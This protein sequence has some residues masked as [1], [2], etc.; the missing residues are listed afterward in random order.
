MESYN[1]V[2][3]GHAGINN[4]TDGLRLGDNVVWQV[5]ELD[6]FRTMAELYVEQARR[7]KRHIVYMRYA[8]HEPILSDLTGVTVHEFDATSGFESFATAV[9]RAIADEGLLAF[10]VFD[11][12]TYLKH[13]WQSD[14]MVMNFFKVTCP[15]LYEL[16]TIAYFAFL[17][18][19]HTVTTIAGI[20]ETTQLLL[21]MHL[22]DDDVY[23]HPLKVWG[24]HSPTMF[25]PHRVT[26]EGEAIPVT[27][28]E[29]TARLFA[30]MSRKS[31]TADQWQVL[32]QSG[33]D[34]LAAQDEAMAAAVKDKLLAVLIGRDGRMVDLSSEHL[35]LDDLLLIARRE[36][37]T[38][39][40]GGKSVGMLVA[41]AILEHDPD[42]RFSARLEPHDSY[43]IGSDLFFTYII[44]NGWWKQWVA[45]KSPEGYFTV[46]A[47]LHELLATGRFP[48]AIREEFLHMLEYF[49]QSPIIVRSSSLLEDNFGNAFAGKYESVFCVNQGTPDERHRQFEDAIRTVYASAMSS[50]AL[51]YRQN[52]GLV[53][54][55]EQMAVLVQR[56][57]G[58][59]HGAAFFPHAAGVGN[60]SNLYVWDPS[61]DMDA[62][63][64][65]LVVG[66]GTRAVDRTHHDYARIVTLDEPTR[67]RLSDPEDLSRYSQRYVDVLNLRSNGLDALPLE[68]LVD[69]DI[70]ADW[71]NFVSPDPYALRVLRERKRPVK[72]VPRVVDFTGLLSATEFPAYMRDVLATVSGAY[73]YPVDIEFTL[74]FD[75][76]GYWKVSLVQCRPLQTRGLGKAVPVPELTDPSECLFS[77]VGN[78]MGGNV[79]LPIDYVV[80]VRPEPYLA[81]GQQEKHGIARQIGVLNRLLADSSNMYMCPGRWGTTT[82]SLGVPVH[83]T[84]VSNAAVLV[85]V[86]YAEGGFRPELS[87]GSHFF[88][89]LVES[90]VFYAAVFDEHPDV[91]FNPGHVME[92]P[93]MLVELDPKAAEFADVIHVAWFPNL[94]L[95]SDIMTQRLVCV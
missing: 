43:F 5:D 30:L 53:D 34:A 88:Q 41:R 63:M 27:S 38:G 72:S 24:R 95:Y 93:N 69:Q 47:E 67:K 44:F 28:S 26:P 12:L 19:H 21:D 86:T 9:H 60:S 48:P 71:T 83:F 49:G 40:I 75:R 18:Y 55:D 84:E 29:E 22:V 81:L 16:D 57:S 78:F 92:R 36:I 91:V 79:R 35:G 90:G 52:R 31:D 25:F 8:D 56:V 17:R 51:T 58:D 94:V 54:M 74:N 89:D 37:G 20:R 82:P 59:H 39:F 13:V 76:D 64:L 6:S 11:S 14:L 62:G 32:L 73:G 66:L 4:L 45:Q 70:K 65:R 2:S 50:E 33:W 61:V 87:Y 80:A 68:Q 23:L 3:T 85:E 42:A 1:W 10:Y 77:T 15:F 7:D 46:G